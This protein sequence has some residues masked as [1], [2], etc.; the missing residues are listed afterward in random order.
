LAKN[1][2]LRILH[3]RKF[4]LPII[5]KQERVKVIFV[6]ATL[7]PTDSSESTKY[8]PICT[9]NQGKRRSLIIA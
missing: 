9:F 1:C 6:I 3:N 4:S 7:I 2:I 5:R 8:V